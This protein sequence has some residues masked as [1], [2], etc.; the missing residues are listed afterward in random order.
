METRENKEEIL[1]FHYNRSKRLETAPQNVKDFYS[2]NF[3]S[4]SKG[5][6]KTIF[7]NPF[8]RL[9]FLAV[10]LLIGTSYFLNLFGPQENT[11]KAEG[12]K[13]MLNSV[14]LEDKIYCSLEFPDSNDFSNR[15]EYVFATFKVYDLDGNLINSDFDSGIYSGKK[16]YFR[17]TF[18]DYE[19]KKV[20]CELEFCGNI[21]ILKSRIK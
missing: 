5:L 21:Y 14:L 15:E 20:V 9:M 1:S 19:I 8:S 4:N 12:V 6:F 10:F 13:I 17:S 11:I 2:G 18:I 3:H 16:T 7:R